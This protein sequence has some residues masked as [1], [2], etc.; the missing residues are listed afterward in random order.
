VDLRELASGIELFNQGKFFEAHEALE[1]VW[2]TVPAAQKKF[3]QGLVQ[4]AV[5]FHHYSTG[6]R[7]G[8][9]SVME[10]A[11]RNLAEGRESFDGI[12][13]QPLL[14]TLAAWREALDRDTAP[15]ALPRIEPPEKDGSD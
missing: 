2:R 9:K 8:M 11:M 6:N 1:D 3:F 14:E 13:V 7:V 5:A 15:P 10:R 12:R 4:V